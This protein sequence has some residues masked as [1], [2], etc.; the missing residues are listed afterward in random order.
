MWLFLSAVTLCTMTST[1]EQAGTVSS[2]I[3]AS[4]RAGQANRI[5]CLNKKAREMG[6]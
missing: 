1:V 2:G 3:R 5:N 4:G 6:S